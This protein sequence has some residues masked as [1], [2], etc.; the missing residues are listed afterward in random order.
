MAKAKND[1]KETTNPQSKMAQL[2]AEK[3]WEPRPL[4][5]GEPVEGKIAVIINDLVLVDIGAKAEG[6]IPRK[7]L[8]DSGE[9]IEIGSTINA[10]IAQTEG[11]S[12]TAVLTVKQTVIEKVW[13][14]LE[15]LAENSESVDVKSVGGNRG[16]VIA[17]YKGVRGFIPSS[18]LVTGTK[19][20][21]G[22]NLTV[23][24]L[25]VN[26]NFNKLVFSEKEATGD[27]LPKIELPFKAD[28]TLKVKISK[29]LNFGLLVSLPS[30]SDGLIHISEISWKKVSNLAQ[31]YKVGQELSAKVISIDPSSG[32]VNLSIKQL[33]KDPWQEA[34]KKY[35]VGA[36]FEKPIS[37]VTS[38]GVF[39]TL[40]EG[41][42]GLLH[43]S[44]I[45][46]GMELK[47]G[48]PVKISVD[49]FNS[50][51]R[52]VALR[53][54]PEATTGDNKEKKK[55]GKRVLATKP[56]KAKEAKK[57]AKTVKTKK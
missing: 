33:E 48:D 17:E 28:D 30:G 16:G 43:S 50:E 57:P 36:T 9:K 24:V 12:G 32:K 13:A 54:A 53:L 15:K 49:L 10:V 51:Q 19:N 29:I 3:G 55:A 44:K 11:D 18:H 40:E 46:Y 26:R 14:Q 25:Q 42:E 47:S 1:T 8:V 23:K 31:I 41:I 4:S 27:T 22:Q 35:K 2:L 6:I 37:R 20:A 34:A 5:K 38:Y 21:I 56:A 45:P 7:E 39:V 52:R